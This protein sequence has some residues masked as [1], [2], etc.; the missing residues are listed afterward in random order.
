MEPLLS[1]WLMIVRDELQER[2]SKFKNVRMNSSAL[3]CH[4]L[5]YFWAVAKEG[6][7]RRASEVLHVSRP[8]ISSQLKQVEESLGAPLFTHTTQRK[9]ARSGSVI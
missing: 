6:G 7:P 5:L 8:S 1:I 4:H 2:R 3:N 9:D